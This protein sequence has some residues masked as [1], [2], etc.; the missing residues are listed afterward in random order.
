[1]PLAP[2]EVQRSHDD[3]GPGPYLEI[4]QGRSGRLSH[5]GLPP[6][7]TPVQ[8]ASQG[9]EPELVVW[10][11]S[12]R[13]TPPEVV[14]IHATLSDG[15]G[16]RAD[17]EAIEVRVAPNGG[18]GAATGAPMVASS[19]P[20]THYDFAMPA[21]SHGPRQ[22]NA[23]PREYHFV[24][25]ATGTYRGERFER[26]AGGFFLVQS[27]G[28][29]LDREAT[30]ADLRRGNLELA[31]TLVVDRPGTYFATAELWGG[32]EAGSPIAFA[33]ERLE[34]LTP[35]VHHVTLLFGGQIVRDSGIDGP[36]A[37]RN[38]RLLQVDTIPPHESEPIAVL[39]ATYD[40]RAR[41]FY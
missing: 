22:E 30:S 1:L 41:D 6:D 18:E 21:L 34:K 10:P 14:R 11:S 27:S 33:R 28:A 37:V 13:V 38:V 40:Y 24:V 31:V 25:R 15:S 19:D 17:A 9:R 3:P 35:G 39:P 32:P 8:N 26:V 23:P 4:Y 5:A 20:G 12:T 36:Y 16:R 7:A 2:S 29:K